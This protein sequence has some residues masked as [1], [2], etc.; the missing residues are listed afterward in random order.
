MLRILATGTRAGRCGASHA[1]ILALLVVVADDLFI[2]TMTVS[3]VMEAGLTL[4]ICHWACTTQLQSFI[5]VRLVSWRLPSLRTQA[6]ALNARKNQASVLENEWAGCQ[7]I[8]FGSNAEGQCNVPADLGLVATVA[9]S[10]SHTCAVR[11][12][13]ELVCFGYNEHGNC[14]IPEDLGPVSAVAT[15]Q[16]HTCALR[17]NGQLLC[18]GRNYN[19]QCDVP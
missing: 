10:G 14:D 9:A 2:K 4:A 18:F 6:V 3:K 5:A 19:G 12:D 7:L 16:F 13:G 8:C 1:S 17:T 15:G 11:V